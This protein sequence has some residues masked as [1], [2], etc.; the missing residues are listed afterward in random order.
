MVSVYLHSIIKKKLFFIF[1]L[2]VFSLRL[3]LLKQKEAL[4]LMLHHHS[5][6]IQLFL[7]C[8]ISDSCNVFL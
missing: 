4:E 5:K 1:D 3:F 6:L 2:V 7:K 8:A